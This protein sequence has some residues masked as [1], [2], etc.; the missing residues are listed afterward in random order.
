MCVVARSRNEIRR[1]KSKVKSDDDTYIYIGGETKEE[2]RKT[3]S[4]ASLSFLETQATAQEYAHSTLRI[5]HWISSSGFCL[6]PVFLTRSRLPL[7]APVVHA[8]SWLLLCSLSHTSR[9]KEPIAY[10]SRWDC[11]RC[12]I[13]NIISVLFFSPLLMAPWLSFFL[14]RWDRANAI[15][16]SS[17]SVVVVVV[18]WI[19][20]NRKR[21]AAR[22]FLGKIKKFNLKKCWLA[23]SLSLLFISLW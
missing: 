12:L 18:V 7:S 4:D 10:S 16:S 23:L 21:A 11:Y 20:R 13:G 22:E 6:H 17:A 8:L 15:S 2:W 1:K 14:F 5:A 9:P 19:N 3:L